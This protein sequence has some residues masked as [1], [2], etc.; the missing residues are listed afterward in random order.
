MVAGK[1][2]LALLGA[3]YGRP[4][5]CGD[6][7]RERSGVIGLGGLGHLAVQF[8]AKLGAEVTV[9]SSSRDKEA[10]ARDLGAK[11]FSVGAQGK[12]GSLD[13]ILSTVSADLDW[14]PFM[15]LLGPDG[16][17]CFVGVAPKPIQIPVFS[18]IGGRKSV[19]GS[20]IGGRKDIRRMLDF[21]AKGGIRAK[22]EAL[23]LAR[24]N[25]AIE[26]V[27]RNQARYRMVLVN[28]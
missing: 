6:Y 13:F 23:P 14:S 25:E 1:C 15:E 17:L 8:A 28:E 19:C 3:D 27:R 4:G 20:P 21:A 9:F 22:T 10:S 26:K 16:K 11:R 5:A 18:L 2:V 24:V 12:P 7:V